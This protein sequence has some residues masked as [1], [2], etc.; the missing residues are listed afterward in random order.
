MGCG[1]QPVTSAAGAAEGASCKAG[2]DCAS[3]LLC[4][5]KTKDAGVCTK[6][7]PECGAAPK[8]GD[9]CLYE[10]SACGTDPNGL[11]TGG[12]CFSIG[13]AITVTCN[14]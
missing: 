11:Q 4:L 10:K 5:A 7:P 6:I 14:H 9:T 2:V 8:C 3:G 12:T 1:T 13:G